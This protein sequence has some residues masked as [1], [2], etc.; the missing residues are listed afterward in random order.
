MTSNV[1]TVVQARW[2]KSDKAQR[3]WLTQILGIQ[4]DG[5]IDGLI[6]WALLL[7]LS[8]VIL[9]LLLNQVVSILPKENNELPSST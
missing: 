3:I 5:W 7:L 1:H 6:A 2:V 4:N 8:V 9:L